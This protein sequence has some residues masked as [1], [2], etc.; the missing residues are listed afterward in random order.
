MMAIL[1]RLLH[2]GE[3]FY[4]RGAS[5]R[6]HGK[7]AM[8]SGK[9]A[10]EALPKPLLGNIFR[11]RSANMSHSLSTTTTRFSSAL[12]NRAQSSKERLLNLVHLDWQNSS[13][14]HINETTV[15]TNLSTAF[16]VL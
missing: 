10:R 9:A 5:Y 16:V 7:E 14:Y 13:D 15:S 8:F 1:D 2:H 6:M 4:L 11:R 12:F 3:V